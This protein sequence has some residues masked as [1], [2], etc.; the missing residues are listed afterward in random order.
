MN[1]RI[2]RALVYGVIIAALCLPVLHLYANVSTC[3]WKAL[4]VECRIVS[5]K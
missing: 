1:D 5:T 4:F 3:G 2:A